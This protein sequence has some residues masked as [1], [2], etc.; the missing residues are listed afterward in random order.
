MENVIR[1]ACLM[2]DTTADIQPLNVYWN[3]VPVECLR[4]TVLQVARTL[5]AQRLNEGKLHGKG[6]TDVGNVSW[7]VPTV[8]M[9]T[10]YDDNGAHTEPYRDAGKSEQAKRAMVSAAEILGVTALQLICDQSLLSR[11]KEEHQRAIQQAHEA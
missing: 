1:G 11:A 9:T 5:D 10:F 4:E 7:V 3:L 8:Y 6:S 2:T